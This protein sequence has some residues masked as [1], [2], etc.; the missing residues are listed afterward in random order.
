MRHLVSVQTITDITPI[1]NADRI[2]NARVLGWNVI[3]KKDQFS[4]GDKI[5][6]FEID[7]L[8]PETDPRYSAFMSRGV[9]KYTDENGN[10]SSG[11]VLRTMKMRGVYSQGL[12]MGLDEIGFTQEQ[13]DSLPVGADITKEAG[14]IK[15]EEPLPAQAGVIGKFNE[16]M[17]PKSDAERVQSL[18][19]HWDEILGLKWIPTVKV[20]GMSQTFANIDGTIHAYSRNW[21]IPTDNTLGYQIAERIGITDVLREHPGMSVQAEL[22]GPG[23][24]KNRLKF[25]TATLKVFAVYQD[26]EKVDREDWD[27]R[28]LKVAVPALGDDWMPRGT[29]DEMIEKVATLRD[30][31]TKGCRDEGI[32]FHLAAGQEVPMWMD[33]NR[34]FK[35][36]SNG[37]LVK[38]NI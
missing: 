36:I 32:V 31:V 21:E 13:I 26:G 17:A 19:E 18:A 3:V 7:S 14:V 9:R 11:H 16:A 12:I 28:L 20:D 27:E 23:I 1:K 4:T 25:D 35:I 37:Y 24:Q 22:F 30:N 33:R 29:I 15:Y 5:A 10:T 8:L 38:H 2:V 34:N 6:Y